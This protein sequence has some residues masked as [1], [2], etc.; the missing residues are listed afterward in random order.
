MMLSQTDQGLAIAGLAYKLEATVLFV[1]AIGVC[2]V[3][4]AYEGPEWMR[5]FLSLA[6]LFAALS[7]NRTARMLLASHRH[8]AGVKG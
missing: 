3:K 8:V 7:A 5:A 1:M 6:L 2:F 4:P